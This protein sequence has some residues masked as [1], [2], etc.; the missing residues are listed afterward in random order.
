[1]KNDQTKQI[2]DYLQKLHE[3]WQDDKIPEYIIPVSLMASTFVNLE[4]EKSSIQDSSSQTMLASESTE[5][6]I[7]DTIP[8]PM[9]D[10]AP[11]A[12][13]MV[14]STPLSSSSSSSSTPVNPP[15]ESFFETMRGMN[16]L[17]LNTQ[18]SALCVI[19]NQAIHLLASNKQSA[20]TYSEQLQS[21]HKQL[22]ELVDDASLTAEF[23][24]HRA[25]Y[26]IDFM[27]ADCDALTHQ[28][29]PPTTEIHDSKRVRTL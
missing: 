22:Q 1:M 25:Q 12:S 26:L 4:T 3:I 17:F 10:D 15:G 24:R 29:S 27:K 5:L 14:D 18:C 19:M 11:V 23:P 21:K 13:T 16:Q 9:A 28:D 2:T 6:P 8:S 7:A 20:L